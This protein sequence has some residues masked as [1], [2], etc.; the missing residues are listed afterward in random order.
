MKIFL[1]AYLLFISLSVCS[2]DSSRI[3][4]IDSIVN[5]INSSNL[6]PVYDSVSQDM[7]VLGLKIKTYLTI[8]LD[9]RKLKKYGVLVNSSMKEKENLK[10]TVSY[11]I[12]YY[13]KNELIKVEERGIEDGQTGNASWYY[14]DDNPL[15]YTLKNDRS[16]ER[17][18]TLLAMS[19]LTIA[20]LKRRGLINQ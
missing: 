16:E 15:Y 8:L 17:A 11:T 13:D 3:K 5:V 12:F 2:Q 19:K 14:A 4:Q 20:E 6:I 9:D 1:I 10:E 18:T 7:P